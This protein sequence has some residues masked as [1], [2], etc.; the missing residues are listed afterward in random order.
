MSKV[1]LSNKIK[2]MKEELNY[3]VKKLVA[4]IGWKGITRSQKRKRWNSG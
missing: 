1:I 2:S 3:Y 4:S